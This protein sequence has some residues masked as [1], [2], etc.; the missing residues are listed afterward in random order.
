MGEGQTDPALHFDI[1]AIEEILSQLSLV[2]VKL[3]SHIM[4]MR[5]NFDV[6]ISEEP[7]VGLLFLF[8]LERGH[9]I[10]RIWNQTVAS[11]EVSNLDQFTSACKSHFSGGKPCIGRPMKEQQQSELQYIV[12][13]T[14]VPRKISSNCQKVVCEKNAA[15]KISSCPAC[16]NLENF[17][18]LQGET[19]SIVLK[20][21]DLNMVDV[22]NVGPIKEEED[23]EEVSVNWHQIDITSDR[24]MMPD[25]SHPIP[26]NDDDI[27]LEHGNE[28]I[29]NENLE[30]DISFQGEGLKIKSGKN[31]EESLENNLKGRKLKKLGVKEEIACTHCGKMFPTKSRLN[32]HVKRKHSA[33]SGRKVKCHH[34]GKI[35]SSNDI[36]NSH[37]KFEHPAPGKSAP[38]PIPCYVCGKML[39]RNLQQHIRNVH[40]KLPHTCSICKKVFPTSSKMY[41]HRARDHTGTFQCSKCGFMCEKLENLNKH[42]LVHEEARFKCSFCEMK[43]RSKPSLIAHERGHTGERPFKCDICENG[44]KSSYVLTAHRKNVHKILTPSQITNGKE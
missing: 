29:L 12:S 4:V 42:S 22:S 33:S 13:Q 34:C 30:S 20:E 23:Y 27:S 11:G 31:F 7:Y 2:S 26:R 19:N 6:I 14:P 44:F 24:G 9:F 41:H 37:I 3:G 17:E 36:L 25:F 18:S 40:G 28:Q 35:Y 16:L 1:R 21:S 8:D 5:N 32:W 43:L 39:K 15:S 10:A 38:A